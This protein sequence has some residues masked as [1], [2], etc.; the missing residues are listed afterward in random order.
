MMAQVIGMKKVAISVGILGI[1]LLAGCT[2]DYILSVDTSIDGRH[3]TLY[4]QRWEV[5][6]SGMYS[7]PDTWH[8]DWGDGTT[9]TDAHA[10]RPSTDGGAVANAFHWEWEHAYQP[11]EYTIVVTHAGE[12]ATVDVVI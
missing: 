3:V 9:S 4:A 1:I 2:H 6:G 10:R 12:K 5:V 8:I 7:A 11:G